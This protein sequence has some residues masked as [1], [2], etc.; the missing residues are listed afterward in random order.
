MVKSLNIG[1]EKPTGTT[2]DFL[3]SLK[4]D[5]SK[6][7]RMLTPSEQNSLRRY[8]KQVSHSLRMKYNIED[9]T[10]DLRKKMAK[11]AQTSKTRS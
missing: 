11:A 3:R 8:S 7:P 10:D 2:S 9:V 5:T 4:H 1:G 6:E